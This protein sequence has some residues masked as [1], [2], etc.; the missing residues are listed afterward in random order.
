MLIYT[1]K[2][3]PW[4]GAS[5]LEIETC[6]SV[7]QCIIPLASSLLKSIQGLQQSPNGIGIAFVSRRGLHIDLFVI[8]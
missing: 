3:H 1:S 5:G 8:V 6:K 2:E 7:Y 4:I